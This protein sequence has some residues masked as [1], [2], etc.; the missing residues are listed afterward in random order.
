M[1][2][3]SYRWCPTEVVF[4]DSLTVVVD[5]AI[6]S[7]DGIVGIEVSGSLR[8]GDSV[9]LSGDGDFPDEVLE[10]LEVLEVPKVRIV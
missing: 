10:V 3:N 4:H 1:L 7:P 6:E 8:R 9:E 2:K 5:G